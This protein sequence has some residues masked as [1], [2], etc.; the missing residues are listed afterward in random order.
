MTND[1]YVGEAGWR[2]SGR[3]GV[4]P[5]VARVPRG[6]RRKI[7]GIPYANDVRVYSAGRGIRQAGRPPYPRHAARV[8]VTLF[9]RDDQLVNLQSV[10]GKAKG[11]HIR[12]FLKLVEKHNLTLKTSEE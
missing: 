10:G 1:E 3:V 12:Q 7:T 4:P 5:A 6:T 8:R 9:V 2:A 11:Y